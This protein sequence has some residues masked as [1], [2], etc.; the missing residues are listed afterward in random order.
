MIGGSLPVT[1]AANWMA[2]AWDQ[3]SAYYAMTPSGAT[4]EKVSLK[5]LIDL[6]GLPSGSGGAF[7]TGATVANFCALAAARHA[8]LTRAGWD[9][10]GEGLFGAPPI[11][12]VGSRSACLGHQGAGD[13]GSG[14]QEVGPCSCG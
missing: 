3:N 8:V 4:L 11:T 5:W 14:P 9:V 6:L 1:L 7:V 13:V 2:G 12:V 10:E